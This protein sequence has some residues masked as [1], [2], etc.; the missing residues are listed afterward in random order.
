M[1]APIIDPIER[2]H[3]A[4]ESASVNDEPVDKQTWLII[5]AGV[6]RQAAAA[7]REACARIA[8]GELME[9]FA[10]GEERI[11]KS[12]AEQIRNRS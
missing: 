12:I 5:V 9:V 2:A 4:W 8:D 7:E 1:T 6:A 3:M 10:A 11:V